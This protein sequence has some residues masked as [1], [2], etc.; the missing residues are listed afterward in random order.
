VALQLVAYCLLSPFSSGVGAGSPCRLGHE[1]I[2]AES[3]DKSERILN[4]KQTMPGR[5]WKRKGV[6]RN[7]GPALKFQAA[8]QAT[9][10]EAFSVFLGT[11]FCW[12]S[13]SYWR[14]Q[15]LSAAFFV[16][17]HSTVMQQRVLYPMGTDVSEESA[18][19][20]F[21]VDV[22]T[23]ATSPDDR[24]LDPSCV[25]AL[26]SSDFLSQY[27]Y[28]LCNRKRAWDVQARWVRNV[29]CNPLLRRAGHLLYWGNNLVTCPTT[30][31]TYFLGNK[32]F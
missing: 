17:Y 13:T 19:S 21:S 28:R 1:L 12:V 22:C 14:L 10:T 31:S 29:T 4:V 11:Q 27:L 8:R 3:T 7:G 24:N 26:C 6:E 15:P 18:A 23:G 32:S 30:W 16:L 20:V 2:H 5:K 9:P 25:I